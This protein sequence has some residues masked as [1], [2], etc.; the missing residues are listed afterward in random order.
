[1]IAA[2]DPLEFIPRGR[3][4]LARHPGPLECPLKSS[5]F[6][7]CLQTGLEKVSLSED[8]V[9]E[10][11][12][13]R[14]ASEENY[15]G[16]HLEETDQ[17]NPETFKKKLD[18][19]QTTSSR[20]ASHTH[21]SDYLEESISFRNATS[22][23]SVPHK[24][25]G[26]RISDASSKY[27]NKRFLCGG[28]S[29]RKTENTH[30]LYAEPLNLN[31]QL[32]PGYIEEEL[33]VKGYTA[34]WSKGL[35][36]NIDQED[37]GRKIISCYTVPFPIKQA[38]WSTFYCERPEFENSVND[39]YMKTNDEPSGVPT[40]SICLVDSHHLRVFFLKGEQFVIPMPFYIEKVWNTKFGILIERC[41]E[42]IKNEK[43]SHE[44]PGSLFSLT[45]P[46]DDICPVAVSRN[47]IITK[48]SATN[49]KLVFTNQNPSICMLFD[50]QTKE[51]SV[52]K[53]RKVHNDEKDYGENHH[54][55]SHSAAYNN[56]QRLKSRLSL[57]EN[58]KTS[59]VVVTPSPIHPKSAHD[60][61]FAHKSRSFS[62]MA[63][64]SRC[65]S[66]AITEPTSPWPQ[67]SKK[68]NMCRSIL[69]DETMPSKSFFNC[70]RAMSHL[71]SNPNICLEHIWTD[72]CSFQ[73]T[74]TSSMAS[75]VF[76]SRDMLGQQYLCYILPSRFQLSVV[77]VDINGDNLAFGLLTSVSAK[78]A[79]DIPHLRM[80]AVLEHSGN[81]T[82]YSGLTLVGKLHLG[83]TLLQ[84]TPSPFVR[85]HTPSPFPRRSSLLPLS[86][87]PE[88]KFDEHLISPVLPSPVHPRLNIL[89]SPDVS[90]PTP[91]RFNPGP[92]YPERNDKKAIIIGLM[93]SIENRFTLKYSDGTFYRITL[94]LNTHCPLIKSCLVALR[95]CLPR[96]AALVVACRWY[97][98][99][100]VLGT[101]N[102]DIS[103]EW[104]MFTAL[105]L[106]LLGYEDEHLF[107]K[108]DPPSTSKR[109][110]TTP[111]QT[112][113]DWMHLSAAY[114]DV[115]HHITR[116]L[117][118][119]LSNPQTTTETNRR[120]EISK[121]SV[122]TKSVLYPHMR[123]IHF[124]LH[125][126]YEDFKLNTLYME[127]LPLLARL[128]SK[129]S[130]NMG[131][132]DFTLHYWKDFPEN[133]QVGQVNTEDRQEKIGEKMVPNI[134]AQI[135]A[136]LRGEQVPP[137][138]YCARVND[139]SKK[140]VQLTGLISET[141]YNK[142]VEQVSLD[143]YVRD[144]MQEYHGDHQ[145]SVVMESTSPEQVVLTM[146]NM[147]IDTKYIETL[148]IG[149]YY[150]FY[151]SL[152]KCR[153]F[154]PADWPLEAYRLVWRDDLVAQAQ[155]V[156]LAKDTLLQ[157]KLNISFQMQETMPITMQEMA[158]L[159]GME[160]IDCTLTKYRFSEDTRVTEA[161]KMLASSKPVPIT[162]TQRPDVSDHDFIE[163][164]ERCLYG[165]CIR[166]MALPVGR[167][168]MTLRTATPIITEPLPA[169]SLCLTGK[170]PPRG[171]TVE[172]NHID[173]PTNMNLWPLFHNGVAN[174]L[175]IIT[176]AQNIDSTWVTF[177]KPKGGT[178]AQME[179][180]GFLM[181]LGLNGHLKNLVS[182]S[183]FEYLT[184]RNLEMASVGLLLGLSADFRGTCYHLLTRILAIH[185]E[186]LLPPT[187]MELD[188][189]HNLLVAGLLGIGLLYQR[190]A[191]RHMTEVLLSEIGRPPG[192]E[193]ENSVDRESHSLAAGLA[194]GLVML[195]QGDHP[196]GM[197]DLNVADTLHYYM[198]GGNIRPLTGSQKDKYK[199]PSF[200]IRE[201]S[202][203]NLDVTAPGATLAIGLMYL[204]SGNKA[205]ADWMAPPET[206]YLLDSVRPDFLML[207]ILSRSLILWDQIEPSKDW[208][209]GQVPSTIRPYCMVTPTNE[210]DIDYEA[211][212]QAYCN[213]VAGACFALGL[214]FAGSA[215]PDAF[216]TLLYVCH[217]FT[218]LTGKSIAELAGK[219]TIETCLN[220]V[221][222]SSAMVMAGTG[223]LEIM[224]LVRHLRRR[225]GIPNSAIV[226]YGSHLAIHMTLGLLFLG[227]GR[228]TLSNSPE[229][230]AALICAFYPKFPTHS[231]D[232]RYHL[233]AFRHLYVLAVEPR[234]VILKD[235]FTDEICYAQLKIVKLDGTELS[236]K[237]PG[238][239]PDINSLT[240]VIVDDLRYWPVVFERGRNWDLL[241]KILSLS[242]Y[243]EMKQRAGCLSYSNDKFGYHSDLARTLTHSNI[244]PWDP[245][246]NSITNFTSN[247]SIRKFCETTL[248]MVNKAKASDFER[249]IIQL[250]TR[251]TYDAVVKDK[252]M[253]IAVMTSLLKSLT[254]LP[255]QQFILDLWQLKIIFQL[256]IASSGTE[257]ISKETVLALHQEVVLLLESQEERLKHS[258]KNFLTGQEFNSGDTQ[259]AAYVTFFETPTDL[260][261]LCNDRMDV[262]ER[263]L[264]LKSSISNLEIQAR[265][266]RIFQ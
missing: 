145:K 216:E 78:D 180:A 206:Q 1:M 17:N 172:L 237:A 6:E 14:Q 31:T 226:T 87:Q 91:V 177:N 136:L 254:N 4:Q 171:I 124:T 160:D 62:S 262:L 147:G 181:A 156:Q 112:L 219:A 207:R 247:N 117:H 89:P 176:D 151:N 23:G 188:I 126:L 163:E 146:V 221:L 259:L 37:N 27:S 75:S 197:S 178:E 250:L 30:K 240:K 225:V 148:P 92:R 224:R 42:S 150:M 85:R 77:K 192:P 73:D 127:N 18:I 106:E 234:L 55:I 43:Y 80:M 24:T 76:L 263:A 68:D 244:V 193:M 155:K 50:T 195:K 88:P 264:Y 44:S 209:L 143:S 84:H 137:Y 182:M 132:K 196:S 64:I 95:Q 129:L 83:G 165:I 265:I 185:I 159:D 25:R 173:T 65:Q 98:S 96:D 122:N 103:N 49:Y 131:L 223:N 248:K 53:I 198:V 116:L 72:T 213:I 186:A 200:Q 33:Y 194:L 144:I 153:E 215:D 15:I 199:T 11:W 241:T 235:V 158:D 167:G 222:I 170:A 166:T 184:S 8:N 227:G 208:V 102:V 142:T 187:S 220:V 140:I 61:L 243:I 51:H 179:H 169:P 253:V 32:D 149:I 22:G 107:E 212:N 90:N 118:F 175:R 69:Q 211:M 161:R 228:Y 252:Q 256:T 13:L 115:E 36:N 141:N 39:I 191:H 94:P 109:Q 154:P 34:V 41:T 111:S 5:T 82:L 74:L 152:W 246:F 157:Q 38:L 108:P 202:T 10:F 217:M 79:I 119:S 2:S 70:S 162:L 20:R 16:N 233:Q 114:K 57:W 133:I 45:Y 231:N 110:K 113:E 93:D 97:S 48:L 261:M 128:L 3:R 236:I 121:P 86:K 232:N 28:N 242:S 123:H 258:L 99:R 210:A 7:D 63:T 190:S 239:I 251:A 168:M 54:N 21:F 67:S 230:V 205:V 134:F 105:L 183:I 218:S 255:S 47:S 203:V 249:R 29:E 189:S 81:V 52:Y 12:V 260:S 238:L 100:N 35:L 214:K 245:D 58:L 138:P 26:K 9:S 125:L 164:Q 120:P 46:L 174:G 71:T 59:D 201:G 101:E 257:L 66:P 229:N 40:F 135:C 130:H 266:L 60:K 19:T 104:D 139:R 56:S 204:G